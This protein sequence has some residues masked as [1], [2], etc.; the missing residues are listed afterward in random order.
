MRVEISRKLRPVVWLA[1]LITGVALLAV[2]VTQTSRLTAQKAHVAE[3]DILPIF[4]SKCLQ[5]HGETLKMA[6]LDLRTRESMLKGGDKGPAFTPG[7]ADQSL[8]IHRVTGKVGPKMPM[9]PVPALTEPEVAILK[10]WINQGANWG[11]GTTAQGKQQASSGYGSDYREKAITEQDRQWWAF[12]KPV[13]HSLPKMSDTRWTKNPID[14]FIKSAMDAKG[15][16]PAPPADRAMLIRR[17]YLDLIGLLPAPAEVDA[18]VRDSSPKAYEDLIEKLL[19]S[20]HYGE[21]WGRYWLDV[22]RYA[23]SSG[24]EHDRDLAT[25]WRYRDYVIKSLNEDKPY[26]RFL[27]EQLAGDELDEP[28][29]DSVTATAFY[30]IGPRVRFREKDNPFYRYDYLDDIVRTTFQ[31]FMGLSV[32]CARCHDH[33]FD[34]VTRMD[35]YRSVAM[36][37]G[38]VNYDHPLMP[39]EQAREWERKTR[40]VISALEPLKKEVSRIEAPYRR[41]QFEANLN[42]LPEEVQAAIKTPVEQR[43]AG[44]KLLAAQFERGSSGDGDPNYMGEDPALALIT[45]AGQRP[46]NLV[47]GPRYG[48]A[49]RRAGGGNSI[50][51]SESDHQRRAEL[52]EK[53]AALEKQMPPTPPA[54]EGIRDGDY[55]LA[56]DGPGDEPSPGKT[57]RPDYPD[58]G[59]S[60]LPEP[61]AKYEVPW[62]RFGANG[63]VVEDDN[64][65]AVVKPGYLTVLAKGTSIPVAKPPQRD[66]FVTSGRRRALA[67]WIAS[68]ENPLTARVIVNRIWYWH[69]GDGIV[70]TPGSFGKMGV[71]PSHP[72][73][74]DWLATEFVSRGWS[75]KQMHRVIMNSETYKMGSAFYNAQNAEKDPDNKFLWRYPVRR[76]EGEI[77]RDIILSASGQINLEAGGTPFFPSLPQRVREGYRQ[78][79]WILTKEEPAT[80]RRS[81]YSYWKRGMKFPMFDVHDQPD[82]NVTTE[83]RNI[84]TV[85]TQ[86][87]T[88]LNNEFVL[89]QAR[90]LAERVMREAGSNDPAAQIKTLYRIALSREPGPSE[91]AG[92]LAFIRKQ[93]EFRTAAANSEQDVEQAALVDLSHV[94]LNANEFVYIN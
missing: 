64:K 63:L 1:R 93:R 15:L 68:P 29:Y 17:A 44:Q 36:F 9:P 62:I 88:L 39:K 55:R 59:T 85:P 2:G 11:T 25:A 84:T 3:K 37:F 13:R 35:Y 14:A 71:A 52:L 28:T 90:Y 79:K 78:G 80:W 70:A 30:R 75:I 32:H 56:P 74:L 10:D 21:R 43:T 4:E 7:H 61:G 5:C 57:Y 23:D 82:Q 38:F 87:L 54:V 60:F 31:G 24:F 47:E 58:L 81:V 67:E 91:L 51:V 34:P 83:K 86:A 22:V 73:L 33:K 41:V 18:F 53:I 49:R 20:P 26:N 65:A 48:G 77:I 69:F 50:K 40:E 42:R 12:R 16:T 66:D 76:L 94:M 46:P 6:N 45:T 92:Q 27:I 8:L 72:E 89:L 19:A